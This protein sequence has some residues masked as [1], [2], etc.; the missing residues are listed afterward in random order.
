MCFRKLGGGPENP[1]PKLGKASTESMA[2]E[3]D[4]DDS[5]DAGSSDDDDDGGGLIAGSSAAALAGVAGDADLSKS[6][7]KMHDLSDEERKQL[8][9]MV[10][11]GTLTMDEALKKIEGGAAA[12]DAG[13]S[14]D[15]PA[16]QAYAIALYAN[17]DPEGPDELVFNEDQVII[18]T[19]QVNEEWLEG[20]I[21]GTDESTKGIFPTAFVEVKVPL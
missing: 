12:P 13:G 1:I 10:K 14:S 8:M 19:R 2:A 20:H 9:T 3:E 17:D 6:E 7:K 18:L 5:S 21:N 16:G 15:V 4:S 11:D